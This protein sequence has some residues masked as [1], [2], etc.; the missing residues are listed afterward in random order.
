MMMS[1][2]SC[3][4]P[5][6]MTLQPTPSAFPSTSLA[7]MDT[8]EGNYRNWELWESS[9][10]HTIVPSRLDWTGLL[11]DVDQTENSRKKKPMVMQAVLC[12]TYRGRTGSCSCCSSNREG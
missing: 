4:L 3:T 11:A 10:F 2:L 7:R 8:G 1:C 5:A 12:L 9:A 6:A